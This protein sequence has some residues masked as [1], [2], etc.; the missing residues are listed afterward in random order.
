MKCLLCE[1]Q[2]VGSAKIEN[3]S[4]FNLYFCKT[5]FIKI[6]QNNDI[7]IDDLDL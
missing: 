7:K 1:N 2:A 3:Y 5:H 6:L 4:G